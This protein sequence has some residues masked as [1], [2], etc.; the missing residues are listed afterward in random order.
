MRRSG[1]Y[2]VQAAIAACH[3]EAPSWSETDWTQILALYEGLVGMTGS[4]VVRLNRAIALSH[5][6]GPARALADI[7][8]LSGELARYHLFHATRAALLRDLGRPD[9]ARDADHQAIALTDNPAER[10]LLLERIG[11]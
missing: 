4:P 9:E 11:Q 8:D 6:V 7:D 2:Q 3:A 1:P 10:A 5:V